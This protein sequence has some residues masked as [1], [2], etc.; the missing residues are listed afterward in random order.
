MND[1]QTILSSIPPEAYTEL[2]K[3]E[4]YTLF[5]IIMAVVFVSLIVA[6]AWILNHNYNNSIKEIRMAYKDAYNGRKKV[7]NNK[8]NKDRK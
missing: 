4:P 5:C 7:N 2:G 6:L 8:S 3:K 1:A